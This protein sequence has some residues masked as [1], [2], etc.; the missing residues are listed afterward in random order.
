MKPA[1]KNE[2]QPPVDPKLL[3][4]FFHPRSIAF[5]GASSQKGPYAF[6]LDRHRGA[7]GI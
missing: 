7:F 1:Q 3:G 5:V 4:Y 2:F 6:H